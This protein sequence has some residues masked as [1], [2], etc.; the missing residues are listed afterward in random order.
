MENERKIKQR[1]RQKNKKRKGLWIL[2][3]I[4]LLL[5]LLLV[6]CSG[7]KKDTVSE[8]EDNVNQITEIDYSEQ[9]EAINAVVEEG[10][11]NVNYSSKAV[12][13]GT[14]SEAFNIKNIRNNHHP[15]VFELYDEEGYC[16]YT[17]K[18]LEPGY[19]MNSIELEEE[20]SEGVHECKLRVGYVEDGNVSSVFP[21][22]IEVK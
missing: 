1:K 16:I 22:T 13:N 19:E 20:L 18:L 6:R 3:A 12:F 15:I 17:S 7:S 4:I 5:I 14:I 2:V 21:I 9:Q 11:M 10:K 8:Y